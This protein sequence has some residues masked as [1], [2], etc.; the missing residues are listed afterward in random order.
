M[1]RCIDRCHALHSDS[2]SISGVPYRREAISAKSAVLGADERARRRMAM[3][4]HATMQQWARMKL[5]RGGELR[6]GY[7]STPAL[8]KAAWS[9]RK[10]GQKLVK[11]VELAG[12]GFANGSQREMCRIGVC[13]VG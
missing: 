1:I 3:L 12:Y 7:S 5:G 8:Q 10:L 4:W 9:G 6:K 13:D 2:S 11:C